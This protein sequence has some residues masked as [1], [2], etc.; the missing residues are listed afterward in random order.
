MTNDTIWINMIQRSTQ[1]CSSVL[2]CIVNSIEFHVHY[3]SSLVAWLWSDI[4]SCLPSVLNSTTAVCSATG[5]KY[6]L[7]VAGRCGHVWTL[8]RSYSYAKLSAKLFIYWDH[9]SNCGSVLTSQ[10]AFPDHSN[11]KLARFSTT[12]LS[13]NDSGVPLQS[14]VQC[15]DADHTW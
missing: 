5:P 3:V 2:W 10:C 12:C 8:D 14:L 1:S 11:C 15:H 9:I 6:D 13:A 4:F 7:W